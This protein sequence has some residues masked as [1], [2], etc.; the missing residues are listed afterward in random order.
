MIR[1]S[2]YDPIIASDGLILVTGAGG[3]I[4]IAV[5]EQLLRMGYRNLRCFVR[6]ARSARRLAALAESNH[7]SLEVLEGNLLSRDDCMRA[8]RNVQVVLHLAAARGEKSFPDAVLNTVVTTRNLIEAAMTSNELKRFVSVSS[9]AVY[10]GEKKGRRRVLDETWPLESRPELRGEA[11][12]FAKVRQ[13]ELLMEYGARVQLPYV[14][15]RPGHVFGRGN[16]AI[17]ARVGI[18]PFGTFLHLGGPNRIPLTCVENCAS[19]IV[20]AGLVPGIEGEAFNIVD[21]DLPTSRHFLHLYKKQVKRFRSIYLPH[22]VSY[23]L[24]WLWERNSIRSQGQIPLAF[25]RRRWNAFWRK[26]GYSNRKARERLGWVP[27]VAMSDGLSSYFEA[28]R[29]THSHA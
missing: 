18:S 23:L 9:F 3:F 12:T 13:D 28:C 2:E 22:V 21:N 11:Y 19:A 27:Q 29:E 10:S 20:L 26:T 24:C 14:I 16:E 1:S 15:V 8:S 7:A 5:V 25:N 4:G 17:S 6:S